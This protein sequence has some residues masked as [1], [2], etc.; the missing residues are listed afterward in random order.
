MNRLTQVMIVAC[1]AAGTVCL[2]GNSVLAQMDPGGI[3]HY[4]GPYPN[5]AYSPMPTGA[6]GSITPGCGGQRLYRSRRGNHGCVRSRGPGQR[7][8]STVDP[9]TGAIACDHPAYRRH[10]LYRSGRHDHGSDGYRCRRHRE[11]RRSAHRRNPEIRGCAARCWDQPAPTSLDNTCPWRFR[12]PHTY[13][14]SDY[15]EIAVV[16]YQEQMHTDLL[17]TRHRGYVQVMR[18][19]F[20]RE[21]ESRWW[22]PTVHTDSKGESVPRPS[23]CD[24]P[25]FLG[26][27]IVS[28][29]RCAGSRQVLQPASDRCRR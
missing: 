6:C 21:H 16:E 26:P 7:L 22:I 11:H 29:Q 1:V 18:R 2:F 17:P 9:V 20:S 24:N 13:P 10:Q 27:V 15:Y 3:P 5:W 8:R 23:P 14:G 12:I 25:H 19:P 28:T 4:F